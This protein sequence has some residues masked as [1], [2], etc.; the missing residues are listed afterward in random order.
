MKTFVRLDITKV[1]ERSSSYHKK[2]VNNT[3]TNQNSNGYVFERMINQ[4]LEY[5]VYE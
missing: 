2:L 4:F 5:I 3:N 1:S